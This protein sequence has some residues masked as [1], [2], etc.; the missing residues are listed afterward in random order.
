MEK[1]KQELADLYQRK[2]KRIVMFPWQQHYHHVRDMEDIYVQLELEKAVWRK[3]EILTLS[4]EAAGFS[5]GTFLITREDLVS[6][7]TCDGDEVKRILLKGLAGSG[8][9]SLLSKLAYDWSQDGNSPLNK[10]E[11]VFLLRMNKL[12]EN[13]NFI[14]T[15][16]KQIIPLS[17]PVKN[18]LKNYIMQN[19]TKIITLMDA[20]DETKI[21]TISID[22]T[23]QGSMTIEQILASEKLPKSLVIV[24]SRPHKPLGTVQSDYVTS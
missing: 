14:D 8:K 9:S 18:G 5:K 4:D 20:W 12:E 13:E 21:E 6:L 11:L 23:Y 22:E 3:K 1:F 2:I 15:I 16:C 19:Q 17:E 10:Y 7:K 24:S